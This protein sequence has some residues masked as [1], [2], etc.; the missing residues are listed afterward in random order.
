MR[1]LKVTPR[2]PR[3]GR[4]ARRAGFSILEALVAVG[5]L[6]IGLL[7]LINLH[8]SAIRGMKAG[9]DRTVASEIANQAIEYY[10][11]QAFD[12][13]NCPRGPVDGCI[14]YQDTDGPQ[15]LQFAPQP[16]C[17]AF[18]YDA[19]MPFSNGAPPPTATTEDQANANNMPIRV[20]VVSRRHP[21]GINHP[22]ANLLQVWVCWKDE[23]GHTRQVGTTRVVPMGI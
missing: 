11:T 8:T 1:V 16:P 5:V 12:T 20:D 7:A 17:S 21:D 22:N 9:A 4:R 18:Y 23:Q 3:S 19:M 10:A 13:L 6:G 14:P 2:R 15:P